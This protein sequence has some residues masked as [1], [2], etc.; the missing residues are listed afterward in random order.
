MQSV[1][2]IQGVSFNRAPKPASEGTSVTFSMLWN[3]GKRNA[4]YYICV[5][6][7]RFAKTLFLCGLE[8]AD[9]QLE[10]KPDCELY[11]II[12]SKGNVCVHL[13][14]LRELCILQ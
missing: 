8:S 10:L 12:M 13:F 14:L 3:S 6:I 11:Y 2:T 7:Y 1:D 9:D 4:F 5:V